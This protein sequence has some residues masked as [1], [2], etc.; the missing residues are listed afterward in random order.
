MEPER[1]SYRDITAEEY[2]KFFDLMT[3]EASGYLQQ[4][5]EFLKI[6]REEFAALF[7]TVG[8]VYAIESGSHVCGFYWSE[9]RE[10][11]LHIH[12][13]V[14]CPEV[15]GKGIGPQVMLHI[16]HNAQKETQAIEVG[17]HESNGRALALCKKMGMEVVREIPGIGFFILGKGL[18]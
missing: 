14:L 8:N 16:E 4:S 18:S 7:R 10:N 11:V 6:T 15:Q 13:L 17:V 2:G 5:L 12:A 9:Y 3:Q 1:L